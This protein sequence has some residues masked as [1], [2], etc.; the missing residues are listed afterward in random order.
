MKVAGELLAEILHEDGGGAELL[1]LAARG[2]ELLALPE[3]GGEGHHL[4]AVAVL[5]PSQDD[6]GVEP[7]RVG[8]HDLV[9]AGH[10]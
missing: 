10:S 4:A 1:G 2:L 7:A 8:E 6:G 5:E 3:V 9:E